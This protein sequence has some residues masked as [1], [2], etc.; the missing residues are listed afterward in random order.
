MIIEIVVPNDSLK[1]AINLGDFSQIVEL[2][3][4][5]WKNDTKNA[6]FVFK[7]LDN[8]TK[9]IETKFYE[10]IR[11]ILKDVTFSYEIKVEEPVQFTSHDI[12]AYLKQKHGNILPLGMNE[13][14]FKID[15]NNLIIETSSILCGMLE[16]NRKDLERVLQVFFSQ[17]LK[18]I[19][20]KVKSNK[21]SK[22]I[23]PIQR[24]V[25]V[26]EDVLNNRSIPKKIKQKKNKKKKELPEGV[27]FGYKIK[28]KPLDVKE[29][30]MEYEGPMVVWGRVFY[31]QEVKNYTRDGEEKGIL[32]F[33]I[34]D[35][36]DALEVSVF[37]S[38][39]EW[40]PAVIKTGDYLKIKGKISFYNGEQQLMARSINSYSPQ[41]VA[42]E[43][44]E[45][46]EK[47]VELHLHSKMSAGDGLIDLEDLF[48]MSKQLGLASFAV[49]D[50][51]VLH[52]YPQIASLS[53]KYDLPAIYGVEGY[54]IIEERGKIIWQGSYPEKLYENM[55]LKELE[56]VV[57][58]LET[59]GFS[60]QDCQIIEIGA[61]KIK[62]MAITDRF[63]C[64]VK[65][66]KGRDLPYKIT[67]LTGITLRDLQGGLEEKEA[68]SQFKDFCGE[69]I[70]V[71]HNA[72]FDYNF[73]QARSRYYELS[74]FSNWALDTLRFSQYVLP[75][76]KKFD[77]KTL[78]NYFKV[79]LINH[80]RAVDDAGATYLIFKEL[81]KLGWENRTLSELTTTL[82]SDWERI[83]P[84]HVVV[85]VKNQSGIRDLY[86]LVSLAHVDYFYK[87][88]LF[89]EKKLLEIYKQGNLLLGTACVE[90]ELIQ[91]YLRGA[92][93]EKLKE[94]IKKY[95]YV[96][97][98][99]LS[100]NQFLLQ[101]GTFN[102][103]QSL[104]K[105]NEYLYKL[106]K[107]MGKL[108]VATSDAHILT[109]EENLAR[110]ILLAG[111]GFKDVDTME[112]LPVWKTSQLLEEFSYLGEE[113]AREI[114]I[115]NPFKIKEQ[116]A[117]G[118]YPIP[119]DF[120]PP[121]IDGADEEIK[122]LSYTKLHKV[123]GE[124]PPQF[125]KDRLERE[126]KSIIG[127]GFAVL[128]LIA[129]KLVKKSNEDGYLVGSR[130]SVGS[131]LVAWAMDITEVNPLPP[132][133]LCPQCKKVEFSNEAP[134]G[135]D[136]PPKK[137]ES[138]NVEMERTG[139]DIPFEVFMGFEGDK[140]PDIDLNF[141]GEYQH[142]I[143][144][145]TEELFGKDYVFR[146]GTISAVQN[147]IA[148]GYV[149]KYF[150]ER[151]I[152]KRKAYIQLLIPK[153][154]G[155]KNTT[156][157]HPGGLM[158]VPRDKSIYDFTPVQYPANKKESGS[159][160]THF[161]YHSIHDNLVKLDLLGHD[162]PTFI[163]EIEKLTNYQVPIEKLNDP[164]MLSLFNENKALDLDT[165][166]GPIPDFLKGS[167][168]LGIPEFG[169]VFVK[170]VLQQ[171]NPKTVDELVKISGLSH[172]TDVWRN[173]GQDLIEAGTATLK[174]IICARDDIMNYLIE[175]GLPPKEAFTIM[176]RVRKGKGLTE[177][178]LELMRK[179][180]VPEWY[181]ESC[182][183]IKYMFPKAHA[184]A[185]VLMSLRIAYYK[186]YF[187]AEFYTDLFYL[188][189]DSFNSI[190][191]SKG[192]QEV[193]NYYKALVEKKSQRNTTKTEENEISLLEIVMEAY[194]R[195]IKFGKVDLDHSDS[196]KFILKKE[197]NLII[198]PFCT[199]AGLGE[200]VANKIVEERHK[201]PF[202]SIKDFK[203]RTSCTQTVINLLKEEGI[204]KGMDE[205]DQISLLF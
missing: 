52:S 96:E 7:R 61:V 169:T 97:L 198:P 40:N 33:F 120:C 128:Y 170:G 82:V 58:D 85:L 112:P 50:H 175:K 167:G 141:S 32:S 74:S 14:E 135:L 22:N 116:I 160:T 47:R 119:P 115:D 199:V 161:D 45:E 57:F 87:K 62:N 151:N 173:N 174:E 6:S 189:R 164:K 176:E 146:A 53:K 71:A 137:C 156:G 38:V 77:L 106:A 16:K 70:L 165:S 12:F 186:V 107:E 179:N 133:Y 122:N 21:K 26:S 163:R 142:V 36:I 114:V 109:P 17:G 203:S 9:E 172:G 171:T 180:E 118:I 59:T 204:F 64:F 8:W 68:L 152:H 131:S 149:K 23:L 103:S 102:F 201:A 67:K 27:L 202:S 139:F 159:L 3:K 110:Q 195:G 69:A 37:F 95:D 155:V 98:Q 79:D 168:T 55:K 162:N 177:E 184:V 104:R 192:L 166:L 150:E 83:R 126:L 100:N 101:K 18:G 145:F 76:N 99:P 185:Y 113:I 10:N 65:L 13:N 194:Y 66:E 158:V 29:I 196:I 148:F 108:V 92:D 75:E 5:I 60:P 19:S 127:N 86:E 46:K 193:M 205:D 132:H 138:C 90:G 117:D 200:S 182:Q 48:K 49:T 73:I 105:M 80:H 30:S 35:E 25:K 188:K 129:H 191:I 51:G 147:N 143:H 89:L 134:M 43:I 190:L 15:A 2:Q 81:L 144:K 28:D 183:K 157:Q 154:L 56:Y 84:Y 187:P 54:L 34:T 4:I 20:L 44:E 39:D 136:L 94:I 130:G 78:S 111:K 140:T 153:I 178:Q 93:E 1:G 125:I 121:I 124:N 11:S 31:I 181:I 42:D 91:N 197:E 88:P 72:E 41:I 123:Y 63:S 24:K